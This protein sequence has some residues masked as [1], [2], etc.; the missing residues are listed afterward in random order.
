[1]SKRQIAITPIVKMEFWPFVILPFVVLSFCHF[2]GN[3]VVFVLLINAYKSR[4]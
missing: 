1:M 3:T 4:Y 2:R